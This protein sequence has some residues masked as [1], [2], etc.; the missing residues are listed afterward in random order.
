M[1]GLYPFCEPSTRDNSTLD[2]Y[3]LLLEGKSSA[4]RPQV[5]TAISVQEAGQ[6]LVDMRTD[7][8]LGHLLVSIY[9]SWAFTQRE[10]YEEF[11]S[12]DGVPY[13]YHRRTGQT[14]WER[15]LYEEEK[16]SPLSGATKV[17]EQ[18]KEEPSVGHAAQEGGVRRA[19]QGEFRKQILTKHESV[20]DATKR[21][22]SAAASIAS[23]KA[24]GLVPPLAVALI[25]SSVAMDAVK[26]DSNPEVTTKAAS[27]ESSIVT[28]G[29]S[30]EAVD[31]QIPSSVALER[32]QQSSPPSDTAA[33]SKETDNA[34]MMDTLT[35]SIDQLMSMHMFDKASPQDMVK[36]GLGMGLAILNQ[37]TATTLSPP[38]AKA[39]I[40][41]ERPAL[42][43]P[44]LA[45][46]AV[47]PAVAHDEK[48]PIGA[49][50]AQTK[51][52][53]N[54]MLKHEEEEAT[55]QAK[56]KALTSLDRAREL[57]VLNAAE[58]SVKRTSAMLPVNADEAVKA[59]VPVLVYPELSTT[60]EGGAP[61][62]YLM[63][64][65]AGVGESFTIGDET[66]MFVKDSAV[67]L[68][69]TTLPFPQGFYEAIVAKHVA[70]QATS[71]LPQVPNLPQTHIVG[72]V[73]P[74]S[75]ARDW[76]VLNFDP[77]S[78]GK[79]PLNTIFIANLA[80]Q[81]GKLF[82]GGEE[83]L[84][85]ELEIIRSEVTRDA[86]INLE[87]R[88]GIA[89]ARAVTSRANV[90]AADFKKLCSLAR[91]G[92]FEEVENLMDQ[93][94]WEVPINYVDD[95]GRTLLHIVAQN[96]NKRLVKLCLR[97]GISINAQTLTGQS[98]LH[99]AFGFGFAALGEYM[100]SKGADDSIRNSAGLTC[101]EGLESK[102]V[103]FL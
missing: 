52:S 25:E 37:T 30:C 41:K 90:L 53:L 68:R 70:K 86:F 9:R 36:L 79:A 45:E 56:A 39:T 17:D 54:P 18:H 7:L 21:R 19:D 69:K 43:F 60:I 78:A 22:K 8:P 72:R 77:W 3:H 91:H 93:S 87:D 82:K 34:L 55:L 51:L 27:V 16:G 67:E 26:I 101:Y 57:V 88:E 85:Q 15:P 73:K 92:K 103:N 31:A 58:E 65:V 64:A 97:R 47:P 24:A 40:A 11:K 5:F 42:F 33:T 62:E 63:H 32:R 4:S 100:I 12:D 66:A 76:L 102:H 48:Y 61:S 74:R 14:F 23:R 99:Y 46:G 10:I 28:I 49:P 71:Y 96:G 95:Q 89:N 83:E 13:W 29:S 81:K 50:K 35:R 84:E 2:F 44:S 59:K 6:F 38:A 20:E 1:D 80:T 75:A 94:D 98:A